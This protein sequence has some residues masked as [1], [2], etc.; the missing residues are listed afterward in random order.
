ML[1][2]KEKLSINN[3]LLSFQQKSIVLVSVTMATDFEHKLNRADEFYKPTKVQ[4]NLV[5]AYP[6][7]DLPQVYFQT[8]ND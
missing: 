4:G 3:W 8:T 5:W 6:G 2:L 7:I 1:S